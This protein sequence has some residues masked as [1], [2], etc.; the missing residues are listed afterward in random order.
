MTVNSDLIYDVL[1]RHQ[2]DHLLLRAT[3]QDAGR[4]LLDIK[5]LSNM[6]T[7]FEDKIDFWQ[8]DYI[9]P[10]A[11]PLML[12]VGRESVTASGVTDMLAE[13]ED[14]LVQEMQGQ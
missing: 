3:T 12:E 1:R 6:L 14:E 7:R 13:L 10:F 5:R 9:S 8:L 11:V 2:P 4:G